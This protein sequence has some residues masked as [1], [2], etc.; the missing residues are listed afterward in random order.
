M[1]RYAFFVFDCVYVKHMCDTVKMTNWG[2]V[3]YTNFLAAVPMLFVLPA[4]NEHKVLYET[5]W[6]FSTVFPLVL[7]CAVGVGMS[8]ASYLLRENVSATYFT[9]IGILCKVVTVIINMMIWDKHASSAGIGFL[10][11][12]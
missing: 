6:D 8:H 10:M 1:R 3:Y 5:V 7:A 12:W 11:I 9:I 4:L 2:R